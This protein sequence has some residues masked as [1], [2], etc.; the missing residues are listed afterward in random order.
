MLSALQQVPAEDHVRYI[1]WD[2]KYYAKLRGGQILSDIVPVMTCAL[3]ETNFFLCAPAVP[4][5]EARRT[6]ASDWVRHNLTWHSAQ[7]MSP[8]RCFFCCA[9]MS[10][11]RRAP[12]LHYI[13]ISHGK[14]IYT[15]SNEDSVS[16]HPQQVLVPV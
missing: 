6:N 13:V 10:A 8:K 5:S 14:A 3:D 1:P 7:Y 4:S 9:R 16:Q 12:Q 2:F 11:Q 15:R